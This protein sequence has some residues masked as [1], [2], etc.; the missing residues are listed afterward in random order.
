MIHHRLAASVLLVGALL[1]LPGSPA[2]AQQPTASS[3]QAV[4]IPCGFS[5]GIPPILSTYDLSISSDAPPLR[6]ARMQDRLGELLFKT[7]LFSDVRT[8]ADQPHPDSTDLSFL[9]SVSEVHRVSSGDPPAFEV[10][11]DILLQENFE[12]SPIFQK[13]E[14]RDVRS[15]TTTSSS[16]VV[17]ATAQIEADFSTLILTLVPDI[18]QA[19]NQPISAFDAGRSQSSTLE[20]LPPVYA[21]P[22]LAVGSQRGLGNYGQWIQ[23]NLFKRLQRKNCVRVV[24][25]SAQTI[26]CVQEVLT[27]T[28]ID[29]LSP[30]LT[31]LPDSA[32]QGLVLL[33]WVSALGDSLGV[34]AALFHAPSMDILYDST[35]AT[36]TG[37]RLTNALEAIASG[38]ATAATS[39]EH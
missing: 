5:I 2:R 20:M 28:S 38:V 1:S 26:S 27:T 18:A 23:D 7:G 4:C 14:T 15:Q 36:M 33:S 19:L 34:G 29:S 11:Y 16:P 25:P 21:I 32:R 3:G 31:C 17:N 8:F 30:I 6:L 35:L 13:T 39:V 24:V 22:T 37:W 12:G 9:V 10:T